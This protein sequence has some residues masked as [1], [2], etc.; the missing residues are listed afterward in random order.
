MKV[1]TSSNSIITLGLIALSKALSP[2]HA[3]LTYSLY[4][5]YK[6]WRKEK[7]ESSLKQFLGFKSNRFGRI[8]YLAELFLE[9]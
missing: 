4:L 9:H 7:S 8:S 5:D 2:S 1:F 6:L 3:A